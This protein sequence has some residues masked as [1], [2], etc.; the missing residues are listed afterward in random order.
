L[1]L[2]YCRVII[3]IHNHNLH[4]VVEVHRQDNAKED[5]I[6]RKLY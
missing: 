2:F 5:I 1:A 6:G 3:W 4:M